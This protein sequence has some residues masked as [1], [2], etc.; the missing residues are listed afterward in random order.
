MKLQVRTLSPWPVRL[1]LEDAVFS[2]EIPEE[3]ADALLANWRPVPEL[4][5]FPRRKAWYHSEP[6]CQFDH[7]EGGSWPGF[8]D[9]L[10]P[11]EF[12][13]F[14]HEDPRFRVPP[15]THLVRPEPDSKGNRLARAVA[16]VSNYG[17]NRFPRVPDLHW[18][19]R[20]VT[21]PKVDL[22][23]REGWRRYRR[24]RFSWPSA[25]ANYRGPIAGDW[26]DAAKRTLLSRYHAVVCLENQCRP[27]YFTEKFMD[28]VAAGA[29]PIYRAHPTVAESFLRG[30]SWIDPA[31]HDDDPER[32]LDAALETDREAVLAAQHTWL[33]TN[34]DLPLTHH[35]A[36]YGRIATIL[37]DS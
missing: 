2:D 33:S 7:L 17:G 31:D 9:R 37:R 1:E 16:V 4:F 12:L 5:T 21:L 22:F 3:K 18:R 8:R 19:N 25:P 13:W 30:A 20:I 26:S 24:R 11:S 32:T 36:V 6:P 14:G 10:A 29:V 34:A 27:Y 28:A 35:L 23:G 15:I